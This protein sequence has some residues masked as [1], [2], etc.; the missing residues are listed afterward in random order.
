MA[1]RANVHAPYT[2][3]HTHGGRLRR[4]LFR[5][6]IRRQRRTLRIG[7]VQTRLLLVTGRDAR[8]STQYTVNT[9]HCTHTRPPP[10][11]ARISKCSARK[12]GRG[13]PDHKPADTVR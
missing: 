5:A 13:R 10:T 1:D 9:G 7:W 12:P 3:T 8:L 4:Y 2:H 6:E 11:S